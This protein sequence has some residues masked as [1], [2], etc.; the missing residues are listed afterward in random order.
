MMKLKFLGYWNV[1]LEH[2][3]HVHNSNLSEIKMK[4]SMLGITVE[5]WIVALHWSQKLFHWRASPKNVGISSFGNRTRL[6][7]G[8]LF[9]TKDTVV[10]VDDF[11]LL[12]CSDKIFSN[13]AK[14]I[15]NLSENSYVLSISFSIS[16]SDSISSKNSLPN[17]FIKECFSV[18]LFINGF[19]FTRSSKFWSISLQNCSFEFS[20]EKKK[21]KKNMLQMFWI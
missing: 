5:E 21:K 6:G 17:C 8:L 13:C 3:Q 7:S 10:I 18:K 9:V 14:A 15:C 2:L 11:P 1:L 16:F 4:C 19:I 20:F 12:F